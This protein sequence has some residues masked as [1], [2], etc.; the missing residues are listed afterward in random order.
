MS[1]LKLLHSGGNGVIIAAPS[2]NPAANRT[3][4]L[5]D[6]YAGDGSFV[7]ANSS[8][9]VGIGTASPD[10]P[11]HIK[12]DTP[13]IKFEDDNDNQDWQIEARAFFSIYDVTDSA[14]RLVINGDGNVGIGN[15]SP[16]QRLHISNSGACKLRLEDTRT[17][18]SD[19][20]E[21]AAIQ[22]EQRDSNT[23]GVAAEIASLM[24]DTSAGATALKFKTG[25]PST[26]TERMRLDHNG[27]LESFA[28]RSS[29]N[30]QLFQ[31]ISPTNPEG[32]YIQFTQAAP[33]SQSRH[34]LNCSDNSQT[35][36][37]IDSNGNLRNN[38]NSYG[39]FSDVS[40]KENIVDAGSQWDD[41][42]NIKVRVFN[43]KKDDPSEKRIGVVAQEIET[44]CPKLVD[45]SY[46]K[47]E[48]GNLLETG[49]KSV[50][51]SVLYMKAIKALQEAQARIE[52][53]EIKVTAL[54]AG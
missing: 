25:T 44:V 6:N 29:S 4:T 23:P 33:N 21:Y 20:S 2:S 36:A 53:L 31:N 45:I 17:S 32:L 9:N 51:Y 10:Q 11:L 28:Y 41:I 12:S 54:E 52:T 7:T 38:N 27:K 16:D 8:G 39:G 50:K 5:N 1:S 14:H 26:I 48:S 13:Y 22:F 35:R 42:K 43:F 40:L 37:V 49:L 19:G 30:A 3:I 15:T 18:I 34:F 24:I 46:D 47:D